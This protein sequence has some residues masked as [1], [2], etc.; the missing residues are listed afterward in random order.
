MSQN[1]NRQQT[2]EILEFQIG[3]DW[4]C[5]C[6]CCTNN[7]R[8]S[9]SQALLTAS[10]SNAKTRLVTPRVLF[11]RNSDEWSVEIWQRDSSNKQHDSQIR[12]ANWNDKFICHAEK[13]SQLILFPISSPSKHEESKQHN[14]RT[15]FVDS[16]IGKRNFNL[17]RVFTVVVSHV[18]KEWEKWL[19]DLVCDWIVSVLGKP[20]L[21]KRFISSKFRLCQITAVSLPNVNKAILFCKSEQTFWLRKHHWVLFISSEFS[22]PRGLV[23]GTKN[24]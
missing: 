5:T 1:S 10:G 20:L 24:A 21:R 9:L 18:H 23:E 7:G 22:C 8:T 19:Q 11:S 6:M 4:W 16:F 17:L 14:N 3:S 12:A 13:T 15:A 2:N